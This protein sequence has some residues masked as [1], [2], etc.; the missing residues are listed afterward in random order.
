[1]NRRRPKKRE[2]SDDAREKKWRHFWPKFWSAGSDLSHLLIQ[3]VRPMRSPSASVGGGEWLPTSTFR[4]SSRLEGNRLYRPVCGGDDISF[5]F[6]SM[7]LFGVGATDCGSGIRE[8]NCVFFSF[9]RWIRFPRSI[10][11]LFHCQ[12]DTVL[13]EIK[14]KTCR[15]QRNISSGEFSFSNPFHGCICFVFS[16]N[17]CF[18][19]LT[20]LKPLTW[21]ESYSALLTRL[22]PTPTCK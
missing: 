11:R 16:P 10:R 19:Y 15:E 5:F 1:M 9:R 18:F 12:I 13:W 3:L 14:K 6:I 8:P 7:T 17:R 4:R 20:S 22:F 21:M 2:P